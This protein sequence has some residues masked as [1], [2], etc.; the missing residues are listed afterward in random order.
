MRKQ[1]RSSSDAAF[2]GVGTGYALFVCS[3]SM[4]NK[5]KVKNIPQKFKKLQM[6]S[7]KW[8]G[9]T[10]PLVKKEVEFF[11]WRPVIRSGSLPTQSN[12]CHSKK[13]GSI[14]TRILT[15]WWHG[16]YM[17]CSVTFDTISWPTD[18]ADRVRSPLE[19]KS[20]QPWTEVRC[21][22]PFIIIQT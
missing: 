22:Q 1:C 20:S 7:S 2:C 21:T 3:N 12:V 10:S 8:Q 18:L 6:D 19:A 13:C 9:W 11:T 17:T 16:P 15:A 4:Q 14:K 5:V